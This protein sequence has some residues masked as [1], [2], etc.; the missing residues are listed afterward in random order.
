MKFDHEV[1]H[2]GVYYP[3][4]TD[5]PIETKGGE[6]IPTPVVSGKVETK[7]WDEIQKRSDEVFADKKIASRKYSEDDLNLPYMKLKKLAKSEGF[8]IDNTAK[9]EEIKELLRS[10]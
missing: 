5:V 3:A 9:A 2:D 4:G 7:E 6:K 1:K 10:L 8:K